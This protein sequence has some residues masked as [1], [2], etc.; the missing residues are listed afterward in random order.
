VQQMQAAL[1]ELRSQQ[2]KQ[3]ADSSATEPIHTA[4]SV[5]Q[6]ANPALDDKS[7]G[8][9]PAIVPTAEHVT[10]NGADANDS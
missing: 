4:L 3:G 7:I 8:V 2:A 9:S 10:E 5:Q 6:S 1:T